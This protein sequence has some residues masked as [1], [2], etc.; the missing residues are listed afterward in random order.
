MVIY[1]PAQIFGISIR[2]KPLD[3]P[4]SENVVIVYG[5]SVSL[6]QINNY[7]ISCALDSIRFVATPQLDFKSG[8]ET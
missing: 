3:K 8:R 4:K 1:L 5:L 7:C 2:A 6:K